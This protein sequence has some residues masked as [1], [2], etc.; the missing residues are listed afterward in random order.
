MNIIVLMHFLFCYEAHTYIVIIATLQI[1]CLSIPRL[2]H[3]KNFKYELLKIMSSFYNHITGG[4]PHIARDR[5]Q[6]IC[7]GRLG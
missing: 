2:L 3:S 1:I 4:I 6:I 7:Q 5:K